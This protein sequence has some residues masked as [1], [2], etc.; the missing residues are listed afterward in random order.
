MRRT[1]VILTLVAL[2]MLTLAL[3]QPLM[4]QSGN[5]WNVA[6]YGNAGWQG[7]AVFS[8]TSYYVYFNWGYG[9]PGPSVPVDY[10]TATMTTDAYFYGGTYRFQALADD[11]IVVTIDGVTYI[12]TVGRGQSGK[13]QVVDIPMT[14]GYHAI[15]VDYREYTNAAYVYLNW[16]Y[17]PP[18]SGA[19]PVP[20]TGQNP[21]APVCQDSVTTQYGDYTPCIEQD[22]HQSN[23][24]QSDGQWDS[25]N[26]GSIEMEPQIQCWA[27]C[28]P[29][30]VR[31]VVVDPTTDPPITEE[32]KCSKTAAGWFPN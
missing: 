30:E 19:T 10:F 4:A 8:Q 7:D 17:L 25:P 9:S 18:G 26:L 2:A 3:G 13:A 23:C 21:T 28:T 16:T 1:V 20:P 29:D 14:Q 31:T 22:I 6:F 27:E 11:E 12:N 5:I 32:I 24:F 15:Q